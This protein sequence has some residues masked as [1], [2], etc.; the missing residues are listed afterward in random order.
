MKRL[1]R[2]P[3]FFMRPRV[4]RLTEG[5]ERGMHAVALVGERHERLVRFCALNLELNTHRMR[6]PRGAAAVPHDLC[7]R[8]VHLCAGNNWRPRPRRLAI[9]SA[10]P[11]ATVGPT[12]C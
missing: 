8:I 2:V 5:A 1:E 9:R 7:R 12:S 3:E 10:T 6:L 11:T 4:T